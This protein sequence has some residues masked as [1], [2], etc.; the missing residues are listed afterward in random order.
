[1]G[2][3]GGVDGP[4]VAVVAV[5]DGDKPG[6]ICEALSDGDS[7]IK[8]LDAACVVGAVAVVDAVAGHYLSPLRPVL[9]Y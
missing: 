3:S 7:A 1:M 9:I 4:L 8:G 5:D 6:V 2:G